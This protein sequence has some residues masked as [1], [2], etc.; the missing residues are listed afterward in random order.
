MKDWP[1]SNHHGKAL[2]PIFKFSTFC[3]NFIFRYRGT[4][5]KFY[6]FRSTAHS[7]QPARYRRP[8]RS[9]TEVEARRRSAAQRS[10][11]STA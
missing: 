5:F 9:G 2:P 4:L 1:F 8:G 10:R 7:V 3:L 6:I 11:S